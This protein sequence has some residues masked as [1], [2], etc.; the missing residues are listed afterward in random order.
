MSDATER[1]WL[2]IAV[3]ALATGLAMLVLGPPL[4]DLL[5]PEPL[6][7]LPDPI[8][9]DSLI[10]PE[11][12]ELARFGLAVLGA[13]ATAAWLAYGPARLPEGLARAGRGLAV[14]GP[15]VVV[16][17]LLV[18]WFSRSEPALGVDRPDYFSTL[19]GV[20]A[21]ALAALAIWLAS[22]ERRPLPSLSA[23]LR[24]RPLSAVLAILATACFL[25]PAAFTD[26]SLPDALEFISIGHLPALFAD[27]T[28]VGNG[29]TPGVDFASQYA[30]LLPYAFAPVL[31]L[32]DYSPGAYTILATLLSAAALLALW[33][34]LC[35][36][37]RS[38]LAG[39]ALYVPVLAI[40]LVPLTVVGDERLS[41]AS[42]YQLLPERYLMPCVL[43]WLVARHLRGLG[44]RAPVALFAVAG[45]AALNNPEFGSAAVLA[46]FAAL[47]LAGEGGPLRPRALLGL[48]GRAALGLAAALLFVVAIDLIR[49]GSLPD[50][51]LL[52]YYS[53]LF[54]SQGFGLI[55][56][57]AT[58]LH[59]ALYLTF[60]GTLALAAVRAREPG[61]DRAT[62][63]LLTFAGLFGLV[64][65]GYYAG[66]SNAYSLIGV[67]PAWGFALAVLAWVVWR[68]MRPATGA[69]AAARAAGALGLAVLV[70][71]GLAATTVTALAP[72]WQQL[73]RL[74]DRSERPDTFGLGAIEAFVA[75]NADDDEPVLFIG[76]N[77]HLI[78]RDAGV[79]N[80][81]RIGDP[82]HLVATEQVQDQLE[83]L[84]AE[85]GEVVFTLDSTNPAIRLRPGITE[86]LAERGY[87][88]VAELPELQLTA[89]R[90]VGRGPAGG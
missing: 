17:V 65:G 88:P 12:T 64:A 90:R 22:R 66:R 68:R 83:A 11:P 47:V 55:A 58:G 9:V 69:A 10:A 3:G 36:L 6:D 4:G 72:P 59:L 35:L 14:V 38:E 18:A 44:P 39:L 8:L 76:Q 19:A 31:E 5:A 15:V 81:S 51:D 41:N 21:L 33:R 71:F 57:P 67:F 89:W 27:F 23:A 75:A 62:V 46:T 74:A 42:Q 80:V 73:S 32:T 40:S 43:A 63:G 78:A 84:E 1:A 77:G 87:R 20:A 85:G 30:A 29:L 86:Y 52:T 60:A 24:R 16:A 26:A 70:G 2:A 54:G 48:L 7:L 82:F 45:L 53:R 79:R 13:V 25:L 56:M 37:A 28:A 61:A 49:A 34:A 50:P